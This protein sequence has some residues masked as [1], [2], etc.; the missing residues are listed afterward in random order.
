MLALSALSCFLSFSFLLSPFFSFRS[1]C[2][3]K[4]GQ[5]VGKI[6]I[7]RNT[8]VIARTE[9]W[10]TRKTIYKILTYQ[11]AYTRETCVQVKPHYIPLLTSLQP[12]SHTISQE[13]CTNLARRWV[14]LLH[15]RRF[16][17]RW[18][19]FGDNIIRRRCHGIREGEEEVL[20][21]VSRSRLLWEWD[22]AAFKSRSPAVCTH[23]HACTQINRKIKTH[24]NARTHASKQTR[25]QASMQARKQAST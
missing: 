10:W 9:I 25:M 14:E 22:S 17:W 19:F 23:M 2:E 8:V 7:P 11:H 3:D 18:A 1:P 20:C 6:F 4:R 5:V 15:E 16:K 21:C 13:H 24:T 12:C